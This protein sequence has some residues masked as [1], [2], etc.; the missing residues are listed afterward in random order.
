MRKSDLT[1]IFLNRQMNQQTNWQDDG[2]AVVRL[3]NNDGVNR[4][5]H[6]VR[7]ERIL[8]ASS[9]DEVM[10]TIAEVQ[11]AVASGYHAAGYIG[12][13]AAGAFDKALITHEPE[14]GPP[15]V[16]FG[17][18]SE[19]S[20]LT[21][22]GQIQVD[23]GRQIWTPSV[24]LPEYTKQIYR[25]K[26]EMRE[27]NTYQVNYSFRFKSTAESDPYAAFVS[28]IESHSA[29][30]AAFINTGE[31][32][33]SS[34]SPELF[35]SRDNKS[36]TCRP[37]KG[38]AP[39]GRNTE[40]DEQYKMALVESVKDRSEN[41]MIVD[42]IRNDLGRIAESGSI[43][44]DHPFAIETYE[45]LF[46]M[47]TTVTARTSASLC[48]IF[49]ALFP[50]ASITGAP[51]VNTMKFIC[52]IEPD[53]RG[54]Y[55]GSIG[56]VGPDRTAQF[57][58]A[59]RTITIRRVDGQAVYG[60]GSGIVWDSDPASEYLECLTKTRI[61]S[62]QHTPFELLETLRWTPEEGYFLLE[63]HMARLASS[64]KHFLFQFDEESVRRELMSLSEM[65]LE[66]LSECSSGNSCSRVAGAE[67]V[68][69]M[70]AYRIRMTLTKQGFINTDTLPLGNSEIPGQKLK[71]AITGSP[72]NQENLY[73]YHKTT[74]REIYDQQLAAHPD[75][76]DVILCNTSGE[77]TESC[78]ANLVAVKDGQHY[79]PP[80]DCGL[81]GGTYRQYLIDRGELTERRIPAD[82][83]GDYDELYLI[84]SVQGRIDIDL[85]SPA[86][87]S[88]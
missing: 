77:L 84:N 68:T 4:W 70:E 3:N 82:S 20:V 43:R 61:I 55:T 83:L 65:L 58:V 42:M 53:P 47:T 46:Q 34:Q 9:V 52:E 73:L 88:L 50:C 30:Y 45:T 21:H 10:Q 35:F 26:E 63:Y 76:D 1:T 54:V 24:T 37:M 16:W 48:E 33:I 86:E 78:I 25:I 59:I 56:Y 80:V 31:Y 5:L 79:T 40:Q 8:S 14:S 75:L 32:I 57:N 12:Y 18:Y 64:A 87:G 22:P 13:E 69:Q 27:G 6:F 29:P 23:T 19:V 62:E 81:L 74:C 49:S 85:V 38:T 44:I 51:K 7:P 67:S 72:V 28:L 60:A 11:Q 2:F 66:N 17:L 36:I 41:L 71:V 39:R 15:L